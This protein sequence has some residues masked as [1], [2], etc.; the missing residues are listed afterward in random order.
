MQDGKDDVAELLAVGWAQGTA[1]G[2]YDVYGA[3]SG[4]GEQYAVDARNVDAL[5][6]AAG[7]GDQRAL[8]LGE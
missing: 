7:V 8:G 5:G 6:Q 2:L 1:D 3:L 4:V